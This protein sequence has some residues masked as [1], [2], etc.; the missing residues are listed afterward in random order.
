M[1]TLVRIQI[2]EQAQLS[3]SEKELMLQKQLAELKGIGVY[4][5]D[6]GVTEPHSL[7]ARPVL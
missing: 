2:A 3:P 5:I 4:V 6:V 7:S 1:N